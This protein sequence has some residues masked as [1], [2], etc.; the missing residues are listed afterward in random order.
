ML[1]F[2]R[3]SVLTATVLVFAVPAEARV[4]GDTIILGSAISLTG[5]YASNGVDSK[6]GYDLAVQKINEAGGVKVDGKSYKLK[7]QYYD[8]ESTPARTAQLLERLIKQDGV[9]YILGP[10]SSPTTIAAAAGD[11]KIQNTHGRG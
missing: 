9:Q 11:G 2:F 6:N 8:D 4:D 3:I 7:V 10:Y 5:K 1:R